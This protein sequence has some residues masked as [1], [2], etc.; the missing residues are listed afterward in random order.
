[1]H[2]RWSGHRS[3][4]GARLT[5]YWERAGL[6][7]ITPFARLQGSTIGRNGYLES[8]A[9]S[10]D[11]TVAGETTNSVR[12]TIGADVSTEIHHMNFDVRLVWERENSDTGRPMSASLSGAPGDAFTVYGAPPERDSAVVGFSFK[13]H[14]ADNTELYARHDGEISAGA[15]NHAFTAELRM[16]W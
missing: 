6:L 9:N 8:G 1:V 14:V 13:T 3:R 11:L 2:W 15:E 16:T 5:S 4:F 12:T 10:L 7:A